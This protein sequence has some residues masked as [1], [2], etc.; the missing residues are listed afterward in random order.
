MP[1]Y[2][3]SNVKPTQLQFLWTTNYFGSFPNLLDAPY[4]VVGNGLFLVEIWETGG[5]AQRIELVFGCLEP[6]GEACL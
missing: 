2:F 3:L 4:P 1:S 5:L 6:I